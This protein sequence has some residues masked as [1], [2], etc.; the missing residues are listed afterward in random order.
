MQTRSSTWRQLMQGGSPNVTTRAKIGTTYYDPMV[1]PVVSRGVFDD[2]P[3]VGRCGI[4]SLS[5]VLLTSDV[6]PKSAEVRLEMRLSSGST[7]S[8]WLPAG[9]YFV[10]QNTVDEATGLVTLTCYDGLLRANQASDTSGDW[11]RTQASEVAH[12]A[13]LLELEI[14]ARTSLSETYMMQKPTG[15]TMLTELGYIA[16]CN[17]GNWM[18]T[19]AGGLRLVP[20]VDSPTQSNATATIYGVLQKVETGKSFT[21]T[22]V[23]MT[24]GYGNTYT[25]GDSTGLNL[26]VKDIP[27]AAQAI[28]DDLY[29]RYNGLT[30]AP[31]TA[32][33][34]VYDPA[35][36]I[37]DTVEYSNKIK[38]VLYS[39]TERFNTAFRGDIAAPANNELRDEY[40]YVSQTQIRI[41]EARRAAEEAAAA[42]EDAA[43][44]ADE[45]AEDLASNYLTTT[46]VT[47][48]IATAEGEITAEVSRVESK[49]DANTQTIIDQQTEIASLNVTAQGISSRVA[50]MEG[51]VET[52]ENH[53][54][55]IQD[56]AAVSVEIQSQINDLDEQTADNASAM[57]TLQTWLTVNASGLSI[58]KSNSSFSSLFTERD[59]EFLEDGNVIAYFG[60]QKYYISNGEI[61]GSLVFRHG[62]DGTT[63][64]YWAMNESGHIVLKKGS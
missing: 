10:S 45:V 2:A 16:A 6:I 50:E 15:L 28:C 4:A 18:V 63:T 20:L 52:V 34:S 44:A 58:A 59:L 51:V 57:Q 14:D 9:T 53:T 40:P 23:T 5:L 12:I 47:Q 41:E 17:G 56:A 22:G 36:E 39:A 43:E 62:A 13:E 55:L 48:R 35:V 25:A 42:A 1:A 38:S 11:P 33:Q 26:Q 7:V 60:N 46:E 30:Y 27:Y 21:I 32:I 19:P 61:T 54:Q 24:D 8:E 49:V 29:T 37:G 64:A 31:F 3:G